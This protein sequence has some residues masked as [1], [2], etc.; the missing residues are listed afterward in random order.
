[1][2][3]ITII[4]VI[5]CLIIIFQSYSNRLKVK[6][7]IEQGRKEVLDSLAQNISFEMDKLAS[8]IDT[9]KEIS[10]GSLL[11]SGPYDRKY[12]K[13]ALIN[14]EKYN[15]VLSKTIDSVFEKYVYTVK[16]KTLNIK[17]RKGIEEYYT[18]YMNKNCDI[19]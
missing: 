17:Y 1:M 8:V 10:S 6:D 16:Y 11:I 15:Y 2:E 7:G 19:L 5:V 14:F 9:D 13:V 3:M 18:F 4:F 12:V